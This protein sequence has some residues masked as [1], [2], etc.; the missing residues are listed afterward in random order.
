MFGDGGGVEPAVGVPVVVAWF[1]L[2]IFLGFTTPWVTIFVIL[3]RRWARGLL[4]LISMVVMVVGP[5]LSLW[6]LGVDGLIRDGVPLV[7]A[8]VLCLSALWASRHQ[9]RGLRPG[10]QSPV[11]PT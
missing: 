2:T 8:G 7:I 3:G 11:R 4:A 10:E 5:A 6:L 1:A 9:P